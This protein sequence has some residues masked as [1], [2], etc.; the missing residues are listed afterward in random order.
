MNELR[1][2]WECPR[3]HKIWAPHIPACDCYKAPNVTASS[4]VWVDFCTHCGAA[5]T[6][7]THHGSGEMRT[8]QKCGKGY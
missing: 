7:I 2:A 1:S 5:N 3:C 6:W 8:C 4:A